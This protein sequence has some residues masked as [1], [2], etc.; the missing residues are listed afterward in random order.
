MIQLYQKVYKSFKKRC[1]VL[2]VLIV[3]AMVSSP[4]AYAHKASIFAWIQGDTIHTLSKT[5]GGKRPNQALVEVFDENGKLLLR[6]KTDAQGQFSFTAPQKSYMKIVL[7]A[8]SGHRAVWSLDPDDFID[9]ASESVHAHSHEDAVQ[10]DLDQTNP[11]ETG[12]VG[13]AQIG[14]SREEIAS[15]GASILDQKLAPIMAKLTEMD[16]N[17]IKLSDISGGLGYIIGL[18]GLGAYMHYHRKT[19]GKNT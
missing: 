5:M 13:Q 3:T 7:D 11:S 12:E 16:Q 17:R 10:T 14:L 18:V 15:L 1:F 19:R 4:A 6:G 8:G 2:L 9:A